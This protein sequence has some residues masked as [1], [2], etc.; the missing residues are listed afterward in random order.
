MNLGVSGGDT[1]V[2]G[3][4]SGD[5]SLDWSNECDCESGGV[6]RRCRQSSNH[7]IVDPKKQ[8]VVEDQTTV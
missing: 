3:N 6:W 7:L 8:R 5:P 4:A 2:I 1:G